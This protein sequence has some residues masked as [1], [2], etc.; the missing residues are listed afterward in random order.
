MSIIA[1][2]KPYFMRYIYPSLM[3]QYNTY[4]SNT[5]KKCLR[6]FR[7]SV[8]ELMEKPEDELT[9]DQ[10]VFL[11]YYKLKMPVGMNNCVMNRIC[12]RFE[13]EFDG[14][15]A[16]HNNDFEFDY[17]I[18]KSGCEYTTTQ[19]NAIK[20]LY[21][22]HCSKMRDFVRYARTERVDSEEGYEV[23]LMIKQNFQRDCHAVCVNKQQL[24]DIM[25][26]I[27]YR[28]E[29]S[30]QFVWEMAG[31]EIIENLLNRNDRY[32]SFPVLDE[33]GDIIFGGD[34]FSF[35]IKKVGG[36]E[37]GYCA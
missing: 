24:C 23:R 9:E 27:C 30:K 11:H 25:L 35:T 36:E 1:D 32:I 16:K 8:A 33:D 13:R 12:R 26:D 18:M 21:N 6:E 2:K 22:D 28:K 29:G 5:N 14:Y 19:Y 20:N 15:I 17:T 3:R 34:K 7:L 4:I 10:K 31:E 37:D